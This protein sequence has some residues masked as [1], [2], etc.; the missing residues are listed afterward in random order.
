[1][2]VTNLNSACIITHKLH[3][4][5]WEP[6]LNKNGGSDQFGKLIWM[7]Y[8]KY[9]VGNQTKCE[10]TTYQIGKISICNQNSKITNIKL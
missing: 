10:S 5:P 9:E 8:D 6:K 1:M 3:I 4:W 2:V 7:K